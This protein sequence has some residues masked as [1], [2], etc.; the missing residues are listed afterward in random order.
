MG[1]PDWPDCGNAAVIELSRSTL[2]YCSDHAL[3]IRQHF[4]AH[5]IRD[6]DPLQPC[7]PK[8]FR[9]MKIISAAALKKSLIDLVPTLHLAPLIPQDG[10]YIAPD[11]AWFRDKFIPFWN[12]YRFGIGLTYRPEVCDCDD[13]AL[14]F[15]SQLIL[16]ARA[17]SETKPAGV[18]IAEIGVDEYGVG[19]HKKNLVWLNDGVWYVVEPQTG[20]F[21]TAE[22]YLNGNSIILSAWL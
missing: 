14:H 12:N 15:H 10:A 19:L 8:P 2:G 22:N 18:A 16:A 3:I 13:F 11:A 5:E 21:Q 9:L 17:A 20:T 4:P 1:P 6:L 7:P